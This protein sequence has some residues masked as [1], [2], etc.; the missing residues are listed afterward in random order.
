MSID[1]GYRC[2]PTSWKLQQ[3]T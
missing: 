3:S 2:G 1:F